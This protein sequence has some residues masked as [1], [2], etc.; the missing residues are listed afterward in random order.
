LI[1]AVLALGGSL[2]AAGPGG[3]PT[4]T[5]SREA[6]HRALRGQTGTVPE[7][8]VETPIINDWGQH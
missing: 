8:A 2:I 1:A 4:R 6:E 5:S 3:P 7:R